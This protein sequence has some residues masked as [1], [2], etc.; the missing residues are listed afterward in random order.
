MLPITTADVSTTTGPSTS[1]SPLTAPA[2]TADVAEMLP[3][4]TVPAPIFAVPIY[5]METSI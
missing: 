2:I 5:Q 1:I 3:I 4:T